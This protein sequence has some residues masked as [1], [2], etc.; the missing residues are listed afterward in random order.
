MDKGI[1]IKFREKEV[2]GTGEVGLDGPT[3]HSMIK[4]RVSLAQVTSLGSSSV[5]VMYYAC[6]LRV[7]VCIVLRGCDVCVC[8]LRELQSSSSVLFCQ[9]RGHLKAGGGRGE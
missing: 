2:I 3:Q 4:S 5:Y 1:I 9:G 8:C 7:R 6:L